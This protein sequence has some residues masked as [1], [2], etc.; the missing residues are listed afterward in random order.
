MDIDARVKMLARLASST[1]PAASEALDREFEAAAKALGS[2]TDYDA[3]EDAIALI[4]VM[5]FRFSDRAAAAFEAFV[6]QIGARQ[7]T[8]S[9]DDRPFG[10]AFRQYRTQSRLL[11]A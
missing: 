10:T 3:L 5:G 9:N 2:A 7:L 6:E 4:E 11:S 8:H 1:T